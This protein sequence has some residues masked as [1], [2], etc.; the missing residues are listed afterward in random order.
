MP[1]LTG[2]GAPR[3]GELGLGHRPTPPEGVDGASQGA[4]PLP[5]PQLGLAGI[6]RVMGHALTGS[7]VGLGQRRWLAEGDKDEEGCQ[8][9]EDADERHDD[10]QGICLL[11]GC[12]SG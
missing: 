12:S 2:G 11:G 8:E 9:E 10:G 7:G 3:A 5:E 6:R 4:Q 1:V